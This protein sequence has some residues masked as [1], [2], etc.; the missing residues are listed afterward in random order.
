M[1]AQLRSGHQISASSLSFQHAFPGHS[2]TI[3][4]PWMSK[5][6]GDWGIT[7]PSRLGKN[8]EDL[9]LEEVG[10]VTKDLKKSD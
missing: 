1:G 9:H 8:E 4:I 5:E 3:F 10:R 6:C 7:S 2:L